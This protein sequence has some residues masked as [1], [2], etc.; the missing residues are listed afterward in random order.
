MSHIEDFVESWKLGLSER[1][2]VSADE[3][4]ELEQHLR[5]SVDELVGARLSE[6]DACLVASSRLGDSAALAREYQKSN[7]GLVWRRRALWVLVGC[8][9]A[10]LLNGL[11][12]ACGAAAALLAAHLDGSGSVIGAMSPIVAL[13][14]W[15]GL[16]VFLFGLAKNGNGHLP[17]LA[18]RVSPSVLIAG[19]VCC[20]MVGVLVPLGARA[21]TA[22]ITSVEVFGNAAWVGAIGL[23]ILQVG[24]PVIGLLM[25]L[26]LRRT[27]RIAG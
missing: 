9:S 10:E 11:M 6:Q 15:T 16:F 24:I 27:I 21:M 14:G 22:S 4:L 12:R 23:L 8:V 18:G 5:E 26:T 7:G 2:S 19:A 25:I 20:I 13:A 3:L 17:Q 1:E